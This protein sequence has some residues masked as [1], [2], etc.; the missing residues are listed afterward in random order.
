MHLI[1]IGWVFYFIERF[2]EEKITPIG[3]VKDNNSKNRFM[4]SLHN[5]LNKMGKKRYICI[6]DYTQRF[7]V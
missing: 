3:H 5:T 4:I 2:A 7:A 6:R 1:A